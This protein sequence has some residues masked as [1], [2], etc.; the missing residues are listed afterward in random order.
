M[1]RSP[2]T[3]AI[4]AAGVAALEER[5]AVILTPPEGKTQWTPDDARRHVGNQVETPLSPREKISAIHSL[6]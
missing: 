1:A 4:Y 3:M 5:F 6:A 2:A